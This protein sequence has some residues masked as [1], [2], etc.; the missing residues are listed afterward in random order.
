MKSPS[1]KRSSPEQASRDGQDHACIQRT[2]TVVVHLTEITEANNEAP[3]TSFITKR[4]STHVGDDEA[5]DE[6]QISDTRV[7]YLANQEEIDEWYDVEYSKKTGIYKNGIVK[8]SKDHWIKKVDAYLKHMGLVE[9]PKKKQK[10]NNGTAKPTQETRSGEDTQPRRK[11]PD[12]VKYPADLVPV[13]EYPRQLE[14][15]E[16]TPN[17]RYACRHDSQN[18]ALEC[19]KKGMNRETKKIAIKKEVDR[20]KMTV[21]KLIDKKQLDM[22]HMTWEVWRTP[23]LREKHQGDLYR[24][25]E[26][27]KEERYR[28]RKEEERLQREAQKKR[29]Q[30]NQRPPERRLAQHARRAQQHL[31]QRQQQQ[32][33]HHHRLAVT[34]QDQ[35]EPLLYHRTITYP[36]QGCILRLPIGK[37]LPHPVPARPSVS[38]E[39]TGVG[40][41]SAP[42]QVSLRASLQATPRTHHQRSLTSASRAQSSSPAPTTKTLNTDQAEFGEWKPKRARTQRNAGPLIDLTTPQQTIPLRSEVYYLT[43][44]PQDFASGNEV[45]DKEMRELLGFAHHTDW[46]MP[47][48]VP[49]I[50]ALLR[51]VVDDGKADWERYCQLFAE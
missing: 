51:T 46:T 26:R 25:Q 30:K 44:L 21:E 32:Q 10:L 42:P 1:L 2:D 40:I 14:D 6:N 35:H 8:H 33:Q 13:P 34:I 3:S 37:L 4:S 41:P 38:A 50:E 23:K 5:D 49:E 48:S 39:E 29:S 16:R 22:Q 20:W 36:A 31:Q 24:K 9:L 11:R 18:S 47:E 17:G 7:Y 28:R 43:S 12:Q 19:C 45:V 15:Y 27:E